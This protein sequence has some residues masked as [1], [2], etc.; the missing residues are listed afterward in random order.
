M[1][2]DKY[3]SQIIDNIKF[4]MNEIQVLI[5]IINSDIKTID[6]EIYQMEKEIK[7]ETTEQ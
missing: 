6:L 3:L 4:E 1:D 7:K 2:K 5:N